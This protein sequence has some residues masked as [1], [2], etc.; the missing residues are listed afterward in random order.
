MCTLS[1][2]S[3]PAHLLHLGTS[4][5]RVELVITQVTFTLPPVMTSKR[6]FLLKCVKNLLI[7][8]IL[9]VITVYA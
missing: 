5:A 3:G 4:V 7:F 6:V 2:C 9:Q 1:L 8:V